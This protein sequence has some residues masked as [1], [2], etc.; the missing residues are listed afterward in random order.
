MPKLS[1]Y[2]AQLMLARSCF[3]TTESYLLE[4]EQTNSVQEALDNVH[5]AY[6]TLDTYAPDI[7]AIN[8]IVRRTQIYLNTIGLGDIGP[9]ERY[10]A[11]S[12][13]PF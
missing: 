6:T 9:L 5:D 13:G 7:E 4:L 3:V 11:G 2:E 1:D 10:E 8:W 12:F